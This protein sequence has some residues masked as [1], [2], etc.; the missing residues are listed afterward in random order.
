MYSKLVPREP[1]INTS[2][3][4]CPEIWGSTEFWTYIFRRDV[5]A[6]VRFLPVRLGEDFLFLFQALAKSQKISFTPFVVHMYRQNPSSLTHRQSK[7]SDC[8]DAL[9]GYRALFRFFRENGLESLARSRA[10]YQTKLLMS[11]FT[12]AAQD[13]TYAECREIFAV[14][15]ETWSESAWNFLEP[16]QP[17]CFKYVA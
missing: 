1:I 2:L 13:L 3:E 5:L 15:R 6:G 7:Y 16:G 4:A 14:F 8:M 9:V 10:Y 17:H 11:T 12:A